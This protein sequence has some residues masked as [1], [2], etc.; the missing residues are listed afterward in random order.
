M[1]KFAQEALVEICSAANHIALDYYVV[2]PNHV[3]AI[4]WLNPNDGAEFKR[5]N[6]IISPTSNREVY[7]TQPHSLQSFVQAFKSSVTRL[8]RK[9]SLWGSKPLW[10]RNYYE[11]VVRT[12][13]ALNRIR[14]YI[15]YNPLSWHLD[16][17]NPKRVAT[18]EF[19]SWLD[20]HCKPA[21]A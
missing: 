5:A 2:M 9:K 17:E 7:G 10:Q 1:G 4:I 19:Y 13:D 14:E 8:A 20:K 21:S 3:H 15:N 12:D 6:H 16:R 18:D 11:H